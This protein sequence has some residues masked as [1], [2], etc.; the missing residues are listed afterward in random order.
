MESE[1]YFLYRIISWNV[2]VLPLAISTHNMNQY[3]YF[4]WALISI[5]ARLAID[6][7]LHIVSS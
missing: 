6:A 3:K 7:D 1:Y 5:S 4:I 2:E